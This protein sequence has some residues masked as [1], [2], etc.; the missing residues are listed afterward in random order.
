[1]NEETL[2]KALIQ[3]VTTISLNMGSIAKELHEVRKRFEAI[4]PR[5][6]TD[7]TNAPEGEH[8]LW[9]RIAQA[10]EVNVPEPIIVDQNGGWIVHHSS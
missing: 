7:G 8:C 10:V 2:L 6:D 9:V 4:T 5:T 1:M 3:V